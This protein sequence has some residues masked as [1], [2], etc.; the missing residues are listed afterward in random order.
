MCQIV[1]VLKITVRANK[2][3][4]ST[5]FRISMEQV[6]NIWR[7]EYW[8]EVTKTR[9]PDSSLKF[10]FLNNDIYTFERHFRNKLT[11]SFIIFWDF[12]MFFRFSFHHKWNHA[13]ILLISMVIGNIRKGK[14]ELVSDILGMIVDAFF[15]ITGVITEAAVWRS[16]GK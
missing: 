12:L 5:N 15:I 11:I 2:V 16:T 10:R 14:L 6:D 3:N 1:V 9:E 13:W 8:N 7:K 4:W